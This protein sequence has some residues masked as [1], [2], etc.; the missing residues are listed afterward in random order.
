M[1][2]QTTYQKWWT[3]HVRVARGEPLNAED[4]AFYESVHRQ[5]EREESLGDREG[6][7][8]AREAVASLET[9]R[10]TLEARR[11]QVERE[12]VALETVLGE[13]TRQPSQADG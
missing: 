11:L 13:Q 2:D 3:L 12:I 9:K 8:E 6:L 10:S 7:R 5:L 1:L 4:H